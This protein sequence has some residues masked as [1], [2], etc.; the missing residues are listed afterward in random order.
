MQSPFDSSR[1][2]RQPFTAKRRAACEITLHHDPLKNRNL[3]GIFCQLWC[4][5]LFC[6]DFRFWML[7]LNFLSLVYKIFPTMPGPNALAQPR[8]I[9]IEDGMYVDMHSEAETRVGYIS[10]TQWSHQATNLV[11]VLRRA[12][13]AIKKCFWRLII[14]AKIEIKKVSAS[15]VDE[16]APVG[17]RPW[18]SSYPQ[19]TWHFPHRPSGSNTQL[20]ASVVEPKLSLPYFFLFFIAISS[21]E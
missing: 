10:R 3:L 19:L 11:R 1:K 12:V 7:R 18:N 15:L 2:V 21:W 6:F 16:F 9:R 20:S 13:L 17:D 4:F 5:V 8:S 14:R